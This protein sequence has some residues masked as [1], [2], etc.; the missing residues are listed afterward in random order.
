MKRN[1]RNV[2]PE[3]KNK[4][5]LVRALLRLN[6]IKDGN[7][8]KKTVQLIAAYPPPLGLLFYDTSSPPY[9]GFIAFL[10]QGIYSIPPIISINPEKRERYY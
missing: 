9:G 1:R 3:D 4:K 5:E 7:G 2:S 6:P 8:L 10:R